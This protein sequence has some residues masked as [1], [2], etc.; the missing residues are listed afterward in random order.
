MAAHAAA[1]MLTEYAHFELQAASS[2]A[3]DAK[4]RSPAPASFGAR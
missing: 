3:L 2:D 4:V 1:G